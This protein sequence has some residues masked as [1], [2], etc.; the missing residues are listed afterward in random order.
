ME[1]TEQ[2]LEKVKKTK[3]KTYVSLGDWFVRMKIA[4]DN[5]TLPEIYPHLL[6]VGYD[7]AKLES[8]RGKLTQLISLDQEQNKARAEKIGATDDLNKKRKEINPL[9]LRHRSLL[10]VLLGGNTM[11]SVSM[12]LSG[13]RKKSYTE[14]FQ[15]V[16]SF[17]TQLSQTPE[18]AAQAANVGITVP[19]VDAQKQ[20]LVEIQALKETQR[21]K[22]ADARTATEAR[23]KA[24]DELKQLYSEYIKYA[25]ILLAGNP[26]LKAIGITEKNR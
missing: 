14:W 2:V 12:K 6:T 25:R 10:K 23:D 8:F 3:H 5:A 22:T 24:F 20:Q 1:N 7:E 9:Y 19:V 17:Y 18:L 21:K 15:D 13:K 11:A 16:S 26:M 4:F